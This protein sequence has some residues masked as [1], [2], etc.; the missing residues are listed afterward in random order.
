MKEGDVVL[1]PLPQADGQV[2]NRPAIILRAMP[3]YGDFLVCGISTQLHHEVAGFDDLVRPSD[4]DFAA[5]SRPLHSSGWASWPSFREVLFW[6]QSDR[7]I[8]RAFC[9]CSID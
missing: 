9:G 4:A 7:S 5:G 1:T 3:P 2:K 8:R 6:V